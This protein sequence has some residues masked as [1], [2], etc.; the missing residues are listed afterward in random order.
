VVT[1]GYRAVR[2]VRAR[3]RSFAHLV[4]AS[5]VLPMLAGA[6]GLRYREYGRAE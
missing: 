5:Q 6:F 2:H 1:E 3:D 4:N